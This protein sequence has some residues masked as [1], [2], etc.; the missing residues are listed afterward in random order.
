MCLDGVSDSAT[1]MHCIFSIHD[2]EAHTCMDG[3]GSKADRS[4]H[5]LPDIIPFW[6]I[7]IKYY[8]FYLY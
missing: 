2:F 7:Q 1:E 5:L 4:F 8:N 3:V 6:Y